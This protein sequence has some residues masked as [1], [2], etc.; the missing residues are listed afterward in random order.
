M[1]ITVILNNKQKASI[2]SLIEVMDRER[3]RPTIKLDM[4]NYFLDLNDVIPDP[5][6]LP[7]CGTSCCLLGLHAF[8]HPNN[9]YT[10]WLKYSKGLG[11]GEPSERLTYKSDLVWTFLFH[12]RWPN[13][14]SHAR[15][16]CQQALDQGKIEEHWLQQTAF[17]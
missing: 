3:E 13:D 17:Y 11:L 5:N 4:S 10:D 7:K 16:R 15:G 9:N 6:K 2:A 12:T 8:Y 14:L 1:S